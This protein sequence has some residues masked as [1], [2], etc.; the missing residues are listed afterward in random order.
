MQGSF[1]GH[2]EEKDYEMAGFWDTKFPA[3]L[4]GE[5]PAAIK[6]RSS[7]EVEDASSN[8]VFPVFARGC[9]HCEA[10]PSGQDHTY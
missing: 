5:N 7:L 8:A 1:H 3:N 4:F 9:F 6:E 10:T 2:F